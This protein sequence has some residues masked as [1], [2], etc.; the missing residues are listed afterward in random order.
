MNNRAYCIAFYTILS[1]E[2]IRVFRIWQQSILPPVITMTLYFVIF[3]GFVGRRV[4][5]IDGIPYMLFIAPGLIMMSSLMNAYSNVSSSFFGAKF[6]RNIDEMLVAPIPNQV[7][8]LGFISGGI[9]RG[10]LVSIAVTMVAMFFTPLHVVHPLIML[11]AILLSTMLFSIAGL[12]NGLIANKFDDVML[13]PTFVL[14]PLI[15][16]GG[17]FYSIN[18]LSP[19]WQ[20][21]SSINPVLYIVNVFRYGMLGHTDV[22]VTTAFMMIIVFIVGLYGLVLY[23]LNKGIGIR[24]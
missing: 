6:Q 1:K 22:N 12:L 18:K 14:T 17:V 2:L 11:A 10:L 8:I 3:G 15:Y 21:I 20:S 16:M 5:T 24:S 4:G 7:I 13:I 23:M 9:L 19:V